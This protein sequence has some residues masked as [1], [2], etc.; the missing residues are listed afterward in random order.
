MKIAFF[1]FVNFL[2]FLFKEIIHLLFKMQ[3]MNLIVII[4]I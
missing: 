1:L 4:L 3:Y 2:Q